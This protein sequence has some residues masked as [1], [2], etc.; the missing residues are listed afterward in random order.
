MR[1]AGFHQ[2]W[3]AG[4][5]N[6]SKM[7]GVIRGERAKACLQQQRSSPSTFYK[8]SSSV[9]GS[10]SP[11]CRP[12]SSHSSAPSS[13]TPVQ[14]NFH[15]ENLNRLAF[16]EEQNRKKNQHNMLHDGKESRSI[17]P[18]PTVKFINDQDEECDSDASR[19]STPEKTPNKTCG[20]DDTSFSLRSAGQTDVLTHVPRSD[21]EVAVE[22]LHRTSLKQDKNR[23]NVFF[24]P[25]GI[26]Y[27]QVQSPRIRRERDLIDR[28]E[29]SL[30][31]DSRLNFRPT[32]APER[33]L[34]PGEIPGYL[35]RRKQEARA[36]AVR[37]ADEAMKALVP[38]G[39]RLIEEAEKVV[40]DRM[41]VTSLTC[42]SAVPAGRGSKIMG[43]DHVG[44]SKAPSA[45]PDAV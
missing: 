13:A 31:S 29:S 37:R 5:S 15:M 25:C 17:H 26:P 10:S 35:S 39:F 1:R 44:I 36:E 32:S 3:R 22:R 19:K 14:K 7:A 28:I 34:K 21:K 20:S 8:S 6:M 38:P 18:K 33:K 4:G 43:G 9:Y 45:R 2:E 30:P 27:T 40:K 42:L 41:H 11:C 16:L 24:T 12:S 23:F